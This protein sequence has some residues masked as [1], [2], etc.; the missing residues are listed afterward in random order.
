[1]L[2]LYET[3]AGYAVFKLQNEKKIK[4]VDNIFEEFETAEKAQ[5]KWVLFVYD[6]CITGFTERIP[7]WCYHSSLQLVS[8]KRFKSTVQAVE[9][10]TSLQEGKLNKTLKKLLK[11]VVDGEQLAVGDA[12]LGSLIK[13]CLV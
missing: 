5:E 1:M 13:V 6:E 9:S 2:V 7:R 10:A 3:A 11:D 4:N 12:K 8:F